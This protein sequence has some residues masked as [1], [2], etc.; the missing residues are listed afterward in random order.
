MN[1]WDSSKRRTFD[2]VS[3]RWRIPDSDKWRYGPDGGFFVGIRMG[4]A[5]EFSDDGE[6]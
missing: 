3:T 1:N 5:T 4:V 2:D 6:I